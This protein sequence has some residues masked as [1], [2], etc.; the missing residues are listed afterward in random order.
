MQ[1]KTERTERHQWRNH[2]FLALGLIAATIAI[3][4]V[5]AGWTHSVI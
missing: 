1:Q 4:T 2:L 5:M 3:A